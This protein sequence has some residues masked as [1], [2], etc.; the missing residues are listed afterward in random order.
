MKLGDRG[1]AMGK[2]LG[3]EKQHRIIGFAMIGFFR[4]ALEMSGAQ[5]PVICFS[6]P[7][8]EHRGHSEPSLAW[9]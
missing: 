7:I 4:K 3:F 2:Y 1:K 5:A 6:T 8:E 9:S